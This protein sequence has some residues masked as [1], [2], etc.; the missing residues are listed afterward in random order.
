MF[1]IIVSFF[2]YIY[3]LQGS[4]KTQLRCSGIYNDRLIANC[5]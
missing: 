1:V 2:S 4:V 5:L 3:L